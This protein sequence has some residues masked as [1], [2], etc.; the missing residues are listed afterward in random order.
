M[1]NPFFIKI[2]PSQVKGLAGKLATLTPEQIGAATVVALND[3]TDNVYELARQR[4]TAGINLTDAY[5][6]RKMRV[7]HASANKLTATITAS[8][9][10]PDITSLSHYGAMQRIQDVNWSNRRIESLGHKFAKWP[11]WTRRT[12]SAK[13]DIPVDHKAAGRSV[14]V[15]RGRRKVMTPM[16]AIPDKKDKDG[17]LLI[18][19]RNAANKLEVLAGPSVYQLFR[20]AA[21][22][23]APEAENRLQSSL[24]AMAEKALRNALP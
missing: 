14:E 8:G 7:T 13:L 11:G 23:I 9:A 5:V 21:V 10:K 6:K 3:A 18:W 20:A 17:N 19:R 4:M 22:V 16:F 1:S 2:D 15:T 12:G 24:S